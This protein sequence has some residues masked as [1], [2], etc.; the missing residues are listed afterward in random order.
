[1]DGKRSL[2]ITADDF[3]IGPATSQG[4]LDLAARGQLTSSVLLVTS[5]YAEQAVLAWQ[6]AGRPMELGWHPCLTLD[7]P[8]AR[9][10]RVSSLVDADGRFWP[11]P[12]FMR[13]LFSGRIRRHDLETELQAQLIR[14][15]DLHGNPPAIVNSHHHVQVF[16][17]VGEVLRHV[18]AGVRPLP[19][20]R[21]I[22]E[23]WRTLFGVPGARIKRAFVTFL[24]GSG[25]RMQAR[26]GFPGNDWLIGITDPPYVADS[27][28]LQRWLRHVPGR[29]VELTCHPGHTDT[30]LIGRDCTANDGQVQRR[31]DEFQLLSHARFHEECQ[32]AGFTPAS[33]SQLTRTLYP[34]S[35]HAA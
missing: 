1:V 32:R 31:C 11:L 9:A 34:V 25:A 26:Q 5:P 17:P 13:R 8:V 10:G 6:R 20:I 4:I 22:C 21:R 19:Y 33:P 7:R 35:V 15:C 18:L 14:F 3:G 23:S 29:T 24:G 30:T 28:F 16:S 12:A 27:L 2:L